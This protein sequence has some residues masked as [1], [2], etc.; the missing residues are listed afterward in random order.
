MRMTFERT[1]GFAGMKMT[2]VIDTETLPTEVANQLRRLVDAADFFHLPTTITSKSRQP[3][4]FMYRITVED[5]SEHHAIE[6]SEQAIPSPLRPL[7]EWL[8]AAARQQ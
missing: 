5:N 7:I 6:V 1:G 4:R 3:D 8:M 2:K